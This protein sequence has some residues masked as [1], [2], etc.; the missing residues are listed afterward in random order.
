MYSYQW[1]KLRDPSHDSKGDGGELL[2]HTVA[3]GA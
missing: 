3:A 2:T 1:G